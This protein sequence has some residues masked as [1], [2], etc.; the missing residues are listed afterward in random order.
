MTFV[1]GLMGGTIVAILIFAAAW[2]FAVKIDNYSIVDAV[3][4]FSIGL[5][6]FGWLAFSST[7]KSWVMG[8]MVMLW[9]LRLGIHLEGRIRKLHPSEDSRYRKLRKMWSG[10]M[11]ISFFVFFQIQAV[12]VIL[13]SLPFLVVATGKPESMGILEWAGMAV[14]LV[15]LIGETVADRQMKDFKA[16]HLSSGSVCDEGLWRYSRHPNY[17]FE[18]VIWLGFYLYACGSPWGWATFHAPALMVYL[19]TKVSGIPA[20]EASSIQSKGDAYR[21]YQSTTNAFVPWFPRSSE[22]TIP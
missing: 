13:L 14:F 1:D 11:G 3:W 22:K 19:L 2:R 7:Y 6:S 5:I 21:T 8:G 20:S 16:A 4:A 15:G 17:F 10:R 12:S 18:F 9:A